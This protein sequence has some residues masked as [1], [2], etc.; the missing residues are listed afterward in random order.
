M[1]GVQV[2]EPVEQAFAQLIY[3]FVLIPALIPGPL[4]VPPLV[5]PPLVVPP[6]VVHLIIV[7]RV[8]LL[9]QLVLIAGSFFLIASRALTFLPIP[10]PIHFILIRVLITLLRD[11]VPV[12]GVEACS[13]RLDL[14]PARHPDLDQARHPDLD[15]A[16]HPD[17]EK[18]ACSPPRE[19][20]DGDEYNEGDET[21]HDGRD[22]KNELELEREYGREHDPEN[23]LELEREYGREHDLESGLELKNRLEFERGYELECKSKGEDEP[24]NEPENEP[25]ET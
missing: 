19:S 13:H 3:V 18:P 25:D 17:L 9:A 1:E 8:R 11:P 21:D 2:A 6:L 5:V 14:D 24:G 7:R 4:V 23:G 10:V 16:R 22:R 12:L 20:K 15:P